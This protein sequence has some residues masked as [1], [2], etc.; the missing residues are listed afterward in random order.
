[1]TDE[2]PPDSSLSAPLSQRSEATLLLEL[3]RHQPALMKAAGHAG[4]LCAQCQVPVPCPAQVALEEQLAPD[5]GAQPIHPRHLRLIDADGD[6]ST[7]TAGDSEDVDRLTVELARSLA[8]PLEIILD[9]ATFVEKERGLDAKET[10]L[11]RMLIG[12]EIQTTFAPDDAYRHD[13]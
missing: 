7:I 13:R 5:D 4:S 9:W 10:A 8:A 11:L 6:T 1:M 12:F 2:M 3:Q